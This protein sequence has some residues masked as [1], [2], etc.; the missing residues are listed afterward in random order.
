M[1]EDLEEGYGVAAVLKG[2][3]YAQG[4]AEGFP[5]SPMRG[6]GL[7]GRGN[8]SMVDGLLSKVKIPAEIIAGDR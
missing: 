5:M 2:R 3:M 7:G 8:D 6:S 4:L 1:G